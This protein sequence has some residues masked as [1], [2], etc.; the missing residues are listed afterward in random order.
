MFRSFITIISVC[1]FLLFSYVFNRTLLR[2]IRGFRQKECRDDRK[3]A[4]LGQTL[5]NSFLLLILI[6]TV[7]WGQVIIDVRSDTL[8]STPS[9]SVFILQ[10]LLQDDASNPELHLKLAE[11]Y[12][13]RERLDEA[14]GEFNEILNVDSLSIHALTGLGRVHFYREPGKIIPFERLKELLKKDHK[15]KAIKRFNQALALNP[16]YQPARYFLARTYLEKGD[17][18]SLERARDEFTR[19][20]NENPDYRDVI[21]QLGYTY[22][23]MGNYTQAI[24]TFKRIKYLVS[25]YAKASIRLAE[26]YYELGDSKSSTDSYFEG[27]EK[28]EDKEM[29]DYLY[30]EQKIILT[31]FEV[32]QF[33]SASFLE[34]KNLFKKFW[35]QRDPDPST[36]ENERLME[37]F[38]RIRFARENFHFTAPPYYDDRGK[39]YI[40][41]G[42]P[43]DR[44]SSPVGTVPAKDNESWTYESIARGLVFDFVSDGGYFHFVE[45]L[46]EAAT[47]GYSYDSRL[48]LAYQLYDQRSHLSQAYANLTVGFSIDRLNSFHNQRIEA[49]EKYPGEIYRHNY[50]ARVFPF[51]TNW[52]QFRGDSNKTR[53]E[54]Y[55]AFPGLVMEFNKVDTGYVNYTDFYIDILDSNFNSRTNL[56]ERYSIVLDTV[57]N[58]ETRHF[59]LQNN[60]QL[61]P[62]SYQ[63]AFVMNNV[64]QSIKGVQKKNM[65]VKDFF[66]DRLLLSDIQLSSRISGNIN[67]LNQSIVK[68]D[69]SII[70][71]PFSRVM[72]SKPIHLYFEIYNLTLDDE[73][74]TKYEISY[75]LKTLR[76]ERNLW[77]KTIGGISRLFS[78]K[79]KSIISTT[80]N[81]EGD[82]DTAFEYI[83]FDLQN[84]ERGLTELRIKVTDQISQQSTENAIEFTLTK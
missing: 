77:Q 36:T 73:N 24:Q 65:Y 19:L 27:V 25:D 71:Y 54:F 45:D 42:P 32:N 74:K 70:P 78:N 55:T 21:Y 18:T 1:W 61:S 8:L 72:K 82:S 58:L 37:H 63:A 2:L 67:H 76:A 62:G 6:T 52:A 60:F 79:D 3:M 31:S 15:S 39:T 5:I 57:L 49:L 51:L 66:S 35:K 81:R 9:D 84:L 10:R 59:L 33:E 46:T 28:L 75:I 64:D 14:E 40:K 44:Y 34:K 43:D 30:E 50:N 53:I 38:R 69:L 7:G 47:P 26:V 20:I 16:G 56:R 17:P 22:Q 41:Y 11:I 23:K 48:A 29:L 80:V 83:S 12:L 68:N 13:Q 4:L